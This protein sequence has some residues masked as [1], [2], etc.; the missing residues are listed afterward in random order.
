MQ[1]VSSSSGA[2]GGYGTEGFSGPDMSR[3][4]AMME[5]MIPKLPQVIAIF[6]EAGIA[7]D[8]DARAAAEEAV[9]TFA[10]L[11][12]P[13]GNGDME[14]CMQLG[15]VMGSIE[16]R[17]RPPME[18]AMMS[19]GKPEVGM[20]I[21]ALMDEGMEGMDDMERMSPPPGMQGNYGRPPA[22][23]DPSQSR[24]GAP[25]P[26]PMPP[27][28]QEQYDPAR[29]YQPRSNEGYPMRSDSAPYPMPPD[30]AYPMPSAGSQEGYEGQ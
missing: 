17:M 30:G 1:T 21:H 13:C 11:R 12:E 8:P 22:M 26:Y 15:Q 9:A 6:E 27:Y 7:V 5:K 29:G 4:L 19:A 25:H 20:R 28:M 3:V 16:S 18:R 14:S 2:A 23:F 10:R 24:E